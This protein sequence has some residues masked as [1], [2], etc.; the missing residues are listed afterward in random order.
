[1]CLVSSRNGRLSPVLAFVEE[2][3]TRSAPGQNASVGRFRGAC[4][5][6]YAAARFQ[7]GVKKQAILAELKRLEILIQLITSSCF[8]IEDVLERR[9][10]MLIPTRAKGKIMD[11]ASGN[12]AKAGQVR[13]KRIR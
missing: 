7:N 9:T 2:L 10:P 8:E 11:H 4:S 3:G 6:S 5:R 13:G 1:M 12:T